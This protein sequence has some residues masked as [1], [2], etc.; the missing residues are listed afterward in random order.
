MMIEHVLSADH[1]RRRLDDGIR[2]RLRPGPVVAPAGTPVEPASASRP[3]AWSRRLKQHLVEQLLPVVNLTSYKSLLRSQ[4]RVVQ[5]M[6]ER[7]QVLIEVARLS[8]ELERTQRELE[9]E[10]ERLQLELADVKRDRD[11]LVRLMHGQ[12]N[13]P[14]G[15]GHG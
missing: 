6:Q 3:R 5:L 1:V 11:R 10:S 12:V 9:S 13:H 2:L 8:A 15:P 14:A 7:D 4:A